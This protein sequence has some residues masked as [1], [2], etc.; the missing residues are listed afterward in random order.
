MKIYDVFV[1]T[2]KVGVLEINEENKYRY[3]VDENAVKEARKKGPVFYQLEKSTSGFVEP[4]PCLCN[5][6]TNSKKFDNEDVVHYPDE[7]ITL[8]VRE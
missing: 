2:V 6:I 5:R 1:N 8:K 7:E 4:I 3:T